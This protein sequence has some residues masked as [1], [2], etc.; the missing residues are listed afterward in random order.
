MD[1]HRHYIFTSINF[2]KH[3][4]RYRIRLTFPGGPGRDHI[5][6]S[7]QNKFMEMGACIV[8]VKY[9]ELLIDVSIEAEELAHVLYKQGLSLVHIKQITH[10][11]YNLS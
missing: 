9:N 10:P 6:K 3:T 5:I 11:K 1:K 2:N 7:L 4:Y 8:H